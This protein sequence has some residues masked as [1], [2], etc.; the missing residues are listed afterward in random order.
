MVKCKL[1]LNSAFA[2]NIDITSNIETIIFGN[3]NN[4]KKCILSD[5]INTDNVSIYTRN[6]GSFVFDFAHCFFLRNYYID[7]KLS[8]QFENNASFDYLL[9]LVDNVKKCNSC[10]DD[11]IAFLDFL[12]FTQFTF[13]NDSFID[14]QR[15]LSLTENKKPNV[16]K[17]LN[18]LDKYIYQIVPTDE[19]LEYIET[20]SYTFVATDYNM[21]ALIKYYL[22]TLY[23]H[24]LYPRTCMR[25]GKHFISNTNTLASVMCSSQCKREAQY[26]R[27]KVYNAKNSTEF[28]VKFMKYYKKWYSKI[29]RIKGKNIPTETEL[30]IMTEMF[31]DFTKGSLTMKKDAKSGIIS[32]EVFEQW[33]AD[34]D[35]AM[36]ALFNQIKNK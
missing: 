16:T 15:H 27:N 7:D 28:D 13:F 23:Q 18:Y 17:M 3:V 34:F 10:D 5:C 19:T 24:N 6:L 9:Q 25:C 1:F 36:T 33:L 26:E 21:Y 4:V 2:I 22:R 11:T 31:D 32:P 8:K 12:D 30:T 29:T 14:A 35:S 20:D